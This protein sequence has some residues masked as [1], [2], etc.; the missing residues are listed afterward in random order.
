MRLV[1]RRQ[2]A[3][4]DGGMRD[5]RR[6]GTYTVEQ[7]RGN[8]SFSRP[9]VLGLKNL[10]PYNSINNVNGCAMPQ[11]VS[12]LPPA[13]KVWVQSQVTECVWGLCWKKSCWERFLSEYFRFSPRQDYSINTPHSFVYLRY[14]VILVDESSVK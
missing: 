3:E 12:R 6:C 9:R 4:K 8:A 10:D 5:G 14:Y 2:P 7:P 11:A 1:F 13:E